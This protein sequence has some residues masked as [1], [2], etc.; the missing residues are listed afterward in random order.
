MG[1]P[2]ATAKEGFIPL[3]NDEIDAFFND[4]DGDKDGFVTI[5]ELEA[6]L[7]EVHR[8]LAPIPQKHHLH[9][10]SRKDLEKNI[11]HAGGGLHAF[12]CSLMPDC[13]SSLSRKDFT[14]HVEKWYVFKRKLPEW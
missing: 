6:K 5:E 13:G 9:H 14:K 1:T 10:T 3:T 8:E 7:H 11:S 2:I 4:L 12:L